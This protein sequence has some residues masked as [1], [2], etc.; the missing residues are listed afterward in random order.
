M[1]KIWELL[2]DLNKLLNTNK[3]T[4]SDKLISFKINRIYFLISK[5]TKMMCVRK[6]IKMFNNKL[7]SKLMSLIKENQ[8]IKYKGTLEIN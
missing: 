2:K 4:K 7:K 1:D 5:E 6:Y 3:S 8:L